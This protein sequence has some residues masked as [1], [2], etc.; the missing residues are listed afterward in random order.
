MLQSISQTQGGTL[1]IEEYLSQSNDNVVYLETSEKFKFIDDLSIVEIINLLS[2]GLASY[3]FHNHNHVPSDIG[4]DN[5]YLAPENMKS[6]EYLEKISKWTTDR[7]MKL[8]T[9]KTNYMIFNF[10][11]N[12]KFNTRLTLEGT[13]LKSK[14]Q[15]F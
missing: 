14:K 10:S 11:K 7:Q 12:K 1:G 13:K 15:S 9:N 4:T 8:N 2:I 3:N 6:H 5:L